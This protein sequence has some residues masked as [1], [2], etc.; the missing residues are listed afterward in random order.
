MQ[1]S[2]VTYSEAARLIGSWFL[3]IKFIFNR[4][5]YLYTCM[6]PTYCIK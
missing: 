1:L 2:F 4:L 5:S 3:F 6:V